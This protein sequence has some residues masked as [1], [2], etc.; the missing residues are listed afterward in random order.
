MAHKVLIFLLLWVSSAQALAS[1]EQ[2]QSQVAAGDIPGALD[3][4]MAV[5]AEE[6][7]NL[8]ALEGAAEAAAAMGIPEMAADFLVQRVDLAV[9]NGDRDTASRIND[10]ITEIYSA[11]P[12]WV[13]AK[14]EAANR[15]TDEQ[16]EAL[17]AID[18]MSLEVD[19]A[20]AAGDLELALSAQEGVL[21]I[22]SD[23][24]GPNHGVVIK[25]NRDLGFIYRNMGMAEE[26]DQYYNQAL[27]AAAEVL[28]PVHPD[29]LEVQSLLGELYGAL[30]MLDEAAT[31]NS[32]VVAGFTEGLGAHHPQTIEAQF[33]EINFLTSNSEFELSQAMTGALCDNLQAA[34]GAYHPETIYCLQTSGG[35][36]TSLGELAAAEATYTQVLERL[37]AVKTEVDTYVTG[38][39]LKLAEI[40]RVLGRYDESKD[41]LS[42]VIHTALMVGDIPAS[43]TA[44]TYLARVLNNQ[45]DYAKAEDLTNEVLDYGLQAW[46]DN[47]ANIYNILLE[48]GSIYQAQSKLADAEATYEEALQGLVELFG[49]GH[50]SSLVARNNLGQIYE[51]SGLYDQAEPLLKDTVILMENILGPSH[52]DTL[53]V[54]NNLALLYESQGN[55][56]E[57]E[58]LYIKS[59]DL[60]IE[61]FGENHNNP[62]A[63]TNNL[64]YLYMLM[65]EYEQSAAMFEEV[66]RR[67]QGIFGPEHQNTLRA[68][69]TWGVYTSVKAY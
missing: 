53:T 61:V 44:R 68:P 45:G 28:G 21:L 46:Q 5:L 41:L 62:T 9:A 39:L 33:A 30:G 11:T 34:Y 7:A 19:Q 69:I 1:L 40:Y 49:E 56:R 26:A 54:R 57:A 29:T 51:M 48:L 15:F 2:A 10:V 38:A 59:R 6:P 42:G 20:L 25:A 4:Y 18:E 23:A 35:I 27:N 36:Q 50:P 63:V 55:F 58:P 65:E 43:Y 24:L 67:W 16:A 22:A 37:G 47:P 8:A 3:S 32:Q 31:I 60:M 13:E 14:T 52:P 12:E 64:A 17:V 66:I